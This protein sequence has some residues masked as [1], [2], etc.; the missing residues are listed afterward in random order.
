ME[1]ELE[2]V[3]NDLT[4]EKFTIVSLEKLDNNYVRIIGKQGYKNIDVVTNGVFTLDF[5][6]FVIVEKI[7]AYCGND[8]LIAKN[9]YGE[10]FLIS[11]NDGVRLIKK[12]KEINYIDDGLFGV[13]VKERFSTEKVFDLNTNDYIPFPDNMVFATYKD[14]ILTLREGDKLQFRQH[15]EMI[16]DRSGNIIIPEVNG[17]ISIIDRTKFITTSIMNAMIIDLNQKVVIQDA[18][19]IHPLADDKIIILKNRKLFILNNAFEVI[20]TYIIGETKRPWYTSVQSEECITMTF[21]RKIHTKKYEPRIEK[22][23]TVIVNVKTDTVSKMDFIPSLSPYEVFTITDNNHKQGLM[24]K[25]SEIILNAEYDSIKALHDTNNKY[26]F[27]EKDEEHYIFNS[28]TRVIKNVSYTEMEEFRDG[29]AMGYTP[30]PINNQ[31]IDEELN[32]VF[33]LKHMGHTRYYYKNGILCYHSGIWSREYDAYT[34]ITQSGETLM[35]SRKCRVKRN[36]FELLEIDDE[37]T[38]EKVLFDMNNGQFIQLEINVPVIE[39]EK[40][41]KFDFSKLPVQQFLS[42]EQSTLLAQGN[43]KDI[44]RL[45]LKPEDKENTKK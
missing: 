9:A 32:V 38:G 13:G 25:K 10:L 44:K 18:D 43:S 16:I 42:N 29:L 19:V 20:K 45:V 4:I 30:E 22:D 6:S 37:Q 11:L 5:S 23:I 26:F 15:K 41:P 3:N 14:G 39:T 36:G 33:N 31:L 24:N 12:V 17:K 35:P 2:S 27:L 34:I 7:I 1:N 40:G 28:E 8:Y 21:K